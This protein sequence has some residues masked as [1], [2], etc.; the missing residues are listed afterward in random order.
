MVDHL[1]P[2]RVKDLCKEIHGQAV[3]KSI[4]FSVYRHEKVVICGPSGSGKTTLLRCLNGLS[5]FHAGSVVMQGIRLTDAHSVQQIRMKTGMLFQGFHLFPHM[6]ILQNCTLA[7]TE[8]KRFTEKRAVELA[9]Y[10]LEKV[11]ISE[12]ANKYPLMLSGGQQQRA[13]IARALCMEPEVLLFDEPTSALDPEMIGEVLSVMNDLTNLGITMICVTHEMHF[14]RK[15]ADRMLFI[16][17]G[18]L[19]LDAPTE[20]F[21]KQAKQPRVTAFLKKIG[22]G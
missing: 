15:F 16:D 1:P 8:V 2:I 18:N 7:L 4:S 10:Y 12:H 13:A 14:A 17:E 21:F 5:S 22:H 20:T 9:H 3:L 19:L 6:T 11:K